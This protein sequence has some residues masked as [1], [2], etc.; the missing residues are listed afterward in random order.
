MKRLN[1][2]AIA[3]ACNPFHG[4]EAG[5]GWGWVNAIA[6]G[7]NV[8][9]ITADYNADQ[10][11][12][13]LAT[14]AEPARN[15]PRFLYVNNRPWHYSPRGIWPK[16][17]NSLAKPLMNIV[18]QDWLGYAFAKAQPEIEQNSYDLVHLITY[19][20]WRFSGRFYQLGIPFVWGPIGGLKNTPWCLFPALGLRGA[21][22][23]G[24][25]NLIN[26]LQIRFLPGPR[27]ALRKAQGAVIAA[28]SEIRD[29][30]QNHFGSSSQVICEVGIPNLESVEPRRR[31][32]SE[33][34]HVCWSGLHLPG[35]ALHLL[36]L[37]AA[38]LPK[39]MNYSLHIL[40]DGPS[41]RKWRALAKHIGIDNCCHWYG[42]LSRDQALNVMKMCHLSAITSLKELTSTV[43]VEALSLGL[44]IICLDH[45]G[46]ADLVTDKCGIKI[47]I[48]SIRQIESDIAEALMVLYNDDELRYRLA[49]GAIARSLLYSWKNKMA[50]LDEIYHMAISR[51]SLVTVELQQSVIELMN[52]NGPA[53]SKCV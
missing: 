47:S 33:S 46:F 22:Y 12:R 2:L 35:K 37:A 50:A 19:V 26:S 31:T 11:N 45:C 52:E 48:H 7:H 23:Y 38:R 10:I 1:V 24:G 39:G 44:P 28:T 25:R 40:G 30:L 9:V 53:G 27:R 4:S 49:Q 17:E 51:H 20:G 21:I 3:Y 15:N 5:V 32:N 18:Y 16:I 14:R 29:A 6:E 41:S 34:L 36:L 8:T 42:H 13:Y 43:A